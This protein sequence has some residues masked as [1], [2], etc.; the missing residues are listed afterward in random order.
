MK[1][2]YP[3]TILP[4]EQQKL[5]KA[6]IILPTTIDRGPLLRFSVGSVLQQ[7]ESSWELFIVGDGAHDETKRIACELAASDERI[8]FFDYEKHPRRGEE[9]RH[10][11]LK[12]ANGEIVCYL[13]DRDLFLPNHLETMYA[14]LQEADFGHTLIIMPS[15][16]G[17]FYFLGSMD[18]GNKEHR[19]GVI[20]GEIGIPLSIAGHRLDAYQRLRYGWRTT[21][22]NEPTDRYMWQQFLVQREIRAGATLIPTV[23]Y[24][25][26]GKHP[27]LST[28]DRQ[29]ELRRYYNEYCR[30]GGAGAYQASINKQIVEIEAK[31]HMKLSRSPFRRVKLRFARLMGQWRPVHEH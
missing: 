17:R 3:G 10:E 18:V 5:V 23:I 8:F 19:N 7:T 28:S 16:T 25:R 21:P 14:L 24:L 13:C 30:L 31:K 2:F 11:L 27:G 12:K 20:A 6:T 4:R 26:R 1:I 29:K 15:P 9:Y 22:K